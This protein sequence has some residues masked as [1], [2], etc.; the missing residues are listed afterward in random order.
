M[1]FMF[2]IAP[3]RGEEADHLLSESDEYMASL[4]PPES[5][6]LVSSES[7]R[8]GDALFLGAFIL[9]NTG[10]HE[11]D[12]DG[13]PLLSEHFA[14]EGLDTEAR[15]HCIG[16]VAARFERQS[17]Y[18][19]IKRLFVDS[20]Y[21]GGGV[22]KALMSAIEAGIRSEDIGCARLE[23]GVSQPEADAFYRATGYYDIPPFGDY[24]IDPLS[25]FLE[26]RPLKE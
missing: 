8:S 7:L 22:A 23:M 13:A 2:F 5:N 17:G 4:Y 19:E 1:T 14:S 21:R 26:K 10:T 18:A 16:C 6:H 12:R 24:R 11:L 9:Q 15:G 20:D 25:Q 3:I